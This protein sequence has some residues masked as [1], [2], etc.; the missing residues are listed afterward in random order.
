MRM[1]SLTPSSFPS[2]SSWCG[3]H[4]VLCAR[5]RDRRRK[6]SLPTTRLASRHSFSHHLKKEPA[7]KQTTRETENKQHPRACQR[8]LLNHDSFEWYE[9]GVQDSISR[10]NSPSI[11]VAVL[12]ECAGG[13]FFAPGPGGSPATIVY[14]ARTDPW[15]NRSD[16]TSGLGARR[17]VF[18]QVGRMTLVGS[19]PLS[20]PRPGH[21][22]PV[23]R[24]RGSH[25]THIVWPRR[26]V[27]ISRLQIVDWR[28][29]IEYKVAA[30]RAASC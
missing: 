16:S 18:T 7:D 12:R 13:V 30:L 25:P 8:R 15:L 23:R 24:S 11:S 14:G 27:V 28:L 6:R 2:I 22:R 4:G 10:R 29:L 3:T 1:W 5:G 9:H 19:I 17:M 21:H 20:T 26:W